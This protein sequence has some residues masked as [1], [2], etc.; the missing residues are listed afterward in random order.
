MEENHKKTEGSKEIKD[1]I[2]KTKGEDTK[3]YENQKRKLKDA[4]EVND[5]NKN[6]NG[7][8]TVDYENQKKRKL[9]DEDKDRT[10]KRKEGKED[11]E[12]QTKKKREDSEMLTLE[13]EAKRVPKEERNVSEYYRVDIMEENLGRRSCERPPV[14]CSFGFLW[15][16]QL[17]GRGSG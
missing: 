10:E 7:E 3:D 11:Y 14:Y 1:R 2:K 16:C 17:Y 4:K 13:V 8:V 6:T 9:K 5:H 12:D 15:R